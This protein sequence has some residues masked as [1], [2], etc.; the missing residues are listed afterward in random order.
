MKQEKSAKHETEEVE[1]RQ[2]A[3]QYENRPV[4]VYQK[5][6]CAFTENGTGRENGHSK[7]DPKG[8]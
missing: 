8:L 7:K 5:C 4:R 3:K 6:A 1:G 2:L